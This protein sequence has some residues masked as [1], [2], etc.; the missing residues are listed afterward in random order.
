MKKK[1]CLAKPQNKQCSICKGVGLVK[2]NSVHN[3]KNCTSKQKY[4]VCCWCENMKFKGTKYKEC[5][6]CLGTGI[7]H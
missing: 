4:T 2:T 7:S 5:E 1:S 3:C 6:R